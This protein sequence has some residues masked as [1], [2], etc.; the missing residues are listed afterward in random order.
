MRLSVKYT[1]APRARHK[2]Y[3]MSVD[4]ASIKDY[5]ML[6]DTVSLQM[7]QRDFLLSYSEV[8]KIISELE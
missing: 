7:L 4:I 5:L 3:I 1:N 2:E 6:L 8:V